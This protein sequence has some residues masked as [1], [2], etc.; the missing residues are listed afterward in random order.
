MIVDAS[1]RLPE[2]EE[3]M[4]RR[5]FVKSTT[6][7]MG[8]L[9]AGL[10]AKSM[11]AREEAVGTAFPRSPAPDQIGRP[12]RV[13]S[14]GFSPGHSLEEIVGLVEK[15]GSKGADI[16]VL[17]E[18][19]RG[20]NEK[21]CEPLDGPT[22]TA[23]ARLASRYHTYIVCPI[24]RQEGSRRFN[25][26]VLLDRQG[27]VVNIY[28]KLYPVWQVECVTKPPVDPGEGIT[29]YT[30]DFG[31]VGFAICFD[32]N[33]TPL[34]ERMANQGAEL[35]VWPSA[36]S[37]GRSLQAQATLF[38]YYI[39]SATGVP[40]CRVFDL[41]GEQLIHEQNNRG[42][43]VNVTHVTLDLDRGIYHQDLNVPEKRDLLLKER[44]ADVA[45]DKWLASE[46]WFMLKAKR[47][48]VSAQQVA[49]QYELED[50]RHYINRSRCE[51]DKCR[52]WEYS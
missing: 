17:P 24:D 44:G 27:Q 13:V 28:N 32:V 25:S 51:I 30:T 47:P 50:L 4:N 49:R 15:E 19:C 1:E 8:A 14:I 22:V 9:A 26:A 7:G 36:Y 11:E 41:D 39:V 23:V 5:Q 42:N 40:D 20:Q 38:N 37:A 35:V 10:S 43:K 33:W 6:S 12:V 18:T 52:G 48:G 31:R 29:V 46:G 16:I 45:Q 3:N 34:W 2:E 21:S